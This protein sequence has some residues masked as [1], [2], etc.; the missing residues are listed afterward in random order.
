M[1]RDKALQSG[2]ILLTSSMA[3][4]KNFVI[5]TIYS[6]QMIKYV[7]I[8]RKRMSSKIE[9]FNVIWKSPFLRIWINAIV[10]FTVLRKCM[11]TVTK[12]QTRS[13]I[14]TFF[15]T[16][17]I[18]FGGTSPSKIHNRSERIL[19]WCLTLFALWVNMLCSSY[20]ITTS[21]IM[22]FQS[23]NIKTMDDLRKSEFNISLPST[24]TN[25]FKYY[26]EL[27]PRLIVNNN[28]LLCVPN[29]NYLFFRNKI[30]LD[31]S[32]TIVRNLLLMNATLSEAFVIP[33]YQIKM[34]LEK[35]LFKN[36][37]QQF[38]HVLDEHF[39]KL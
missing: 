7:V 14:E 15:E 29:S 36:G 37:E 21:P 3:R 22:A 17:G 33:E 10:W 35:P 31:N 20:L 18:L 25:G 26:Q 39:C 23:I 4:M 16:L 6:H 13:V 9:L 8:V 24:M 2:P 1:Y 30:T 32:V 11:Q 27:F 34:I 5:D 19:I 12:S 28:F 38:Y